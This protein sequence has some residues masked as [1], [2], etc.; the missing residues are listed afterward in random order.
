MELNSRYGYGVLA[1]G[2]KKQQIQKG[3]TA[4]KD[5]KFYIWVNCN[6]FKFFDELKDFCTQEILSVKIHDRIKYRAKPKWKENYLFFL[7]GSLIDRANP[8]E[9]IPQRG[10]YI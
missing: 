8:Q 9:L 5:E 1:R 6:P 10:L 7:R 3:I 4:G 2:S